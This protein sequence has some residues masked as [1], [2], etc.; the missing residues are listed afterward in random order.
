[1]AS[2]FLQG[3]IVPTNLL[4]AGDIHLG[5]RPQ[6]L[7][8]A[9]LDPSRF[10]PTEAWARLVDVAI[11]RRVDAVVL[12][13]DVV[14]DERDRFEAYGHLERGIRRLMGEGIAT[15][16][17]AGNHDGIALPRLADRLADFTLLGRGGTWQRVALESGKIPVDLLGWSFSERHHRESPLLSPGLTPA[18]DGRRSDATLLGVLHCD[19]GATGGGYAPISHSELE[20]LDVDGWFLGHIHR[21]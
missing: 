10:A 15:V 14:D 8:H 4:F 7:V 11:E 6:R 18:L 5:R 17:V 21:P 3:Y 13:G 2:H 1:M 19:L 12:A 20:R 9:E 16:G